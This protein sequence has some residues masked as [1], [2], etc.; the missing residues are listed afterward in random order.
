M[1]LFIVFQQ[2]PDYKTAV[3]DTAIPSADDFPS[4]ARPDNHSSSMV[5]GT[6]DDSEIACDSEDDEQIIEVK[7]VT[8]E[9]YEKASPAQ[10]DL[11]KVLGQG[12]FGKVVYNS[13]FMSPKHVCGPSCPGAGLF[14]PKKWRKRRWNTLRDEG[15]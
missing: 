2:A 4:Q 6:M 5:N 8:K 1:N 7:E 14:G 12:S 9:G 10:F 11:L 3:T 13:T 15:P